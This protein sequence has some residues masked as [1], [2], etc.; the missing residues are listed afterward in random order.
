MLFFV[1]IFS[2]FFVIDCT[3]RHYIGLEITNYSK[4]IACCTFT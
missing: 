4:N 2:S 3:C 1:F